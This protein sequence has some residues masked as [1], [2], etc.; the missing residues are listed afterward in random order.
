V[1]VP[2]SR[3]G[4]AVRRATVST[5]PQPKR[6]CSTLRFRGLFI[7]PLAD[8]VSDLRPRRPALAAL[9]PRPLL[10]EGVCSRLAESRRRRKPS[11]PALSQVQTVDRA[12]PGAARPRAAVA[13]PRRAPLAGRLLARSDPSP[14]PVRPSAC[15]G[16]ATPCSGVK[17]RDDRHPCAARSTRADDRGC[18]AA[19]VRRASTAEGLPSAGAGPVRLTLH[20]VT[21]I[22][23]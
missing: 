1:T 8:A 11:P 22:A 20:A 19:D 6:T 18:L 17:R 10:A 12:E 2:S 15:A 14:A 23:Q 4:S 3:G 16:M 5:T 7:C 9:P 13:V 21:L